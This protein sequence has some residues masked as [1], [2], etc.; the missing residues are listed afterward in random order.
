MRWKRVT[1]IKSKIV[2]ELMLRVYFSAL[3]IASLIATGSAMSP[4]ANSHYSTV[5][6]ITQ[7]GNTVIHV[8]VADSPDKW[9][10]GLMYRNSLPAD[11]GMLFVFPYEQKESFTM[12]NT[13]IPLDMIFISGDMTIVDINPEA[14][15]ESYGIY[16]S[17]PSRYVI[18]VNG[19]FCKKHGIRIGDRVRIQ[20]NARHG[21]PAR[22]SRA[23]IAHN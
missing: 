22:Y 20:G 14:A 15:P 6:F 21:K 1:M 11:G 3:F 7:S 8:E 9:V 23:S 4:Y 17:P 16:L 2:F 10:T 12:R 5:Y 13:L 19:G 18:E